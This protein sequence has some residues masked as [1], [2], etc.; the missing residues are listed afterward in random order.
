MLRRWG[1]IQY[2]GHLV[3][4][5]AHN[6]HEVNMSHCYCF[7]ATWFR[8][9]CM[10]FGFK[11]LIQHLAGGLWVSNCPPAPYHSPWEQGY[12]NTC[13]AM[14]SQGSEVDWEAPGTWI[15]DNFSYY[16]FLRLS[17]STKVRSTCTQTTNFL[18]LGLPI[19]HDKHPGQNHWHYWLKTRKE[20]LQMVIRDKRRERRR[21]S[22]QRE[23][24]GKG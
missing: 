14:L 23:R 8:R 11:C 19:S 22:G 13:S 17:L 1:G 5:L 7:H 18:N 4:Y 10:G 12:T 15:L 3:E 20:K 6:N 2:L 21:N 16:H 24:E 9:I